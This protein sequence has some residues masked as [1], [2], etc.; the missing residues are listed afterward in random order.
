MNNTHYADY[1]W[2][3][4]KTN[5][6]N[7]DSVAKMIREHITSYRLEHAIVDVLVVKDYRIEE[8]EEIHPSSEK[9]PK[10]F[11]ITKKSQWIQI[12]NGNFIRVRIIESKPY[13]GMIF[14]RML[15]EPKIHRAVLSWAPGTYFLGVAGS[16]EIIFDHDFNQMVSPFI[17]QEIP[18]L[19]K[20][21]LEKHLADQIITSSKQTATTT[22]KPTKK[23]KKTADQLDM[24]IIPELDVNLLFQFD[25]EDQAA[26]FGSGVTSVVHHKPET[27]TAETTSAVATELGSIAS[28]PVEPI[29][30]IESELVGVTAV[31]QSTP[32]P[33]VSLAEETLAE[34]V[35]E[36]HYEP[37]NLKIDQEVFLIKLNMPGIVKEIRE[38]TREVIV[39]IEMMGRSNNIAI[40]PNDIKELD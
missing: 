7:E 38:K 12:R 34:P 21:L 19:Q 6:S 20:Y 36:E 13:Q 24:D 8:S 37:I 40:D 31:E 1:Y 22:A 5:V 39:Q 17:N 3:A 4:L 35:I 10:A 26:G 9:L 16:P 33:P 32:T 28:T 14:V 25:K 30:V 2:Y 18:D 23:S 29:P 27:A 11:R 15:N